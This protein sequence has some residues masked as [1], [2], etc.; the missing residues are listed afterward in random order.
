MREVKT[1]KPSFPNAL[2]NELLSYAEGERWRVLCGDEDHWRLGIYSPSKSAPEQVT[3]LEW[4]DCPELFLLIGGEVSLLL[5]D[6][7]GER[8]LR[9]EPRKPALITCFH[10]GFCPNGAH[11]GTCLVIERDAF[12]TVYKTRGEF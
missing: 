12:K 11:T 9:L 4:H 3:E 5:R 10:T 1:D 7:Q 2:E 8:V 6:E